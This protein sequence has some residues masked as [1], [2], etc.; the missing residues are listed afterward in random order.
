MVCASYFPLSLSVQVPPDYLT[1]ESTKEG[2]PD[3]RESLEEA[4][5]RCVCVNMCVYGMCVCVWCVVWCVCVC[6]CV[7]VCMCVD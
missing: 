5:K 3:K 7:C 4:D 1:L 2:D 6:V